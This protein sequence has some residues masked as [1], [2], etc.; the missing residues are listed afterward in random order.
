MG[1]LSRVTPVPFVDMI[2]KVFAWDITWNIC[3]S[4]KDHLSFVV[5]P[6]LALFDI[7]FDSQAV[8][9]EALA[10]YLYRGKQ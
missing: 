8:S 6:A 7:L 5:T 1:K 4:R 3:S 2:A 10:R 9:N